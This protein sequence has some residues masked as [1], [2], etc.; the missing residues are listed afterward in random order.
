MNIPE[1]WEEKTVLI[2][3]KTYPNPSTKYIETVCTAGITE[4]GQLIRIY[5]V[6]H[7]TLNETQKYKKFQWIKAQFK[8]ST[9]PRPESYKINEDSIE[10]VGEIKSKNFLQRQQQI[11]PLLS[12][13]YEDL[14][15]RHKEV[16]TSLGIIEPDV[17]SIQLKIEKDTLEWTTD[18]KMKLMQ[19]QLSLFN[20]SNVYPLEKIPYNFKL[21][22][23]CCDARCKGH[24]STITDWEMCQ[25]YRNFK[26]LYGEEQGLEELKKK[27]MSM[28]QNLETNTYLFLGTPLQQD[29]FGVFIIIG[30][31]D[32]RKPLMDQLSFNL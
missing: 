23:K 8:K 26:N 25:A 5:P 19:N 1:T 27:Y 4:D 21:H 10:I 29:R 16:G 13:S 14:V 12:K 18:Q 30:I 11:T 3:V 28:F 7:R 6:N 32:I 24:N 22:Y 31:S 9:D 17:S 2:T 15:E 20:N